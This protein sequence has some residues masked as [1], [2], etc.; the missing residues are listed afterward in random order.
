MPTRWL[1]KLIS[2]SIEE[3]DNNEDVKRVILLPLLLQ[4]LKSIL[5]YR[6]RSNLLLSTCIITSLSNLIRLTN[7][8]I[9]HKNNCR[10]YK[11]S[12]PS[13]Y[14]FSSKPIIIL[15]KKKR[16]RKFKHIANVN[17]SPFVRLF[18][19]RR[20]TKEKREGVK[21]RKRKRQYSRR[22]LG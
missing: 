15:E 11:Q 5:S 1:N 4:S 13:S 14:N 2:E 16:K 7:P 20:E 12:S 17:I 9:V 3:I 21:K 22:I 18:P 8:W 6:Y 19:P 10:V